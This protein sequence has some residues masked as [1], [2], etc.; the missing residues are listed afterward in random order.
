MV[1]TYVNDVLCTF[2]CFRS[3]WRLLRGC[4][5]SKKLRTFYM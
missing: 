4:Y 2:A 3:F 1:L 5:G